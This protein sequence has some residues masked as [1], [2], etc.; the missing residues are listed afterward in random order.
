M[1]LINN[2][3]AIV[4]LSFAVINSLDAQS[5]KAPAFAQ[6]LVE[7]WAAI[8]NE[9]HPNEQISLAA[10]GTEGDIQIVVSQQQ[11][12]A[13]Q[14]ASAIFGR[15]AILPFVA[16]G[17]E[18]AKAFG[19]KKLNKTRIEHIYFNVDDEED[20][21]GDYADANKGMTIYSG[22]SQ[23]TIANTFAEYFGQSAT[24]FRGK[25][26]QGD[27]RFVNLAVSRDQKGIAFNALS[28]LFDLSTRH[29]KQGIQ[30][31]GL[32]VKRDVQNALE[33]GDLDQLINSLEE[34]KNEAIATADISLS[35]N[36]N[37]KRSIQFVEWVLREGVNYN[38]RFGILNNN[39]QVQAQSRGITLTA[40]N[41]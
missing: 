37:D 15:F 40:N 16:E 17:S 38:H 28:N 25:R 3:L 1:K 6:P 33:E 13:L 21:F 24:A 9:S 14:Q 23:A 34:S 35:Y 5:I 20:E 8:Y 22:N 19:S 7:Q 10:K 31:L 36:G 4:A 26:I 18:A 27:D 29:L 11:A 12:L 2:I 41:K 32:D 39:I 30:I